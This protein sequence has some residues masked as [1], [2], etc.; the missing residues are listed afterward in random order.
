MATVTREIL[1]ESTNGEPIQ[2]S[3]TATPG[4]LLH[5]TIGSVNEM[6]EVWLWAANDAGGA[7]DLTLELGGTGSGRE[8]RASITNGNGPNLI[9]QGATYSGSVN[10]RAFATSSGINIWGHVNRINQN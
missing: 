3:A 4:D 10:V 8:S 7:V 2:V 1:T 5:V 6:D 9:L